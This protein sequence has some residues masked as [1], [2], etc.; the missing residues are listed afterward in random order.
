MATTLRNTIE[1]AAAPECKICF[2]ETTK[3]NPAVACP[4]CA[5]VA[6][7]T[8]VQT[9]LLGAG[10]EPR[11][12]FPECKLPWTQ[13][14]VDAST[15]ATW[16][17]RDLKKAREKFLCD[18][19]VARLP[20][21]QADAAR[22]AYA[23]KV[24][25]KAQALK[26]TAEE[27]IAN[28]SLMKKYEVATAERNTANKRCHELSAELYNERA[29]PIPN[30]LKIARLSAEH[31]EALATAKTK[32]A[33]FQKAQTHV[34]NSTVLKKLKSA[35]ALKV[36]AA[37]FRNPDDPDD[38]GMTY[39]IAKKTV[40]SYGLPQEAGAAPEERRAFIR[41]CPVTDCK[42]FLSSAWKCGLCSTYVCPDC[43][44]VKAARD[45]S[46]HKCDKE[47]VE[48]VRA[49]AKEARPCPK[50][51][52]AIS[53]IDGCDMMWCTLCQTAFSWRTGKPSSEEERIHNPHYYDWMRRNG[54]MI[55]RADDPCAGIGRVPSWRTIQQSRP[56]FTN[57]M[58]Q[59]VL[60]TLPISPEEKLPAFATPSEKERM[61]YEWNQTIAWALLMLIHRR[62]TEIDGGLN[63]RSHL[64]RPYRTEADLFR[65]LRVQYLVGELTKEEFAVK[66]QQKHKADRKK[67]VAHTLLVMLVTA[68][69][70][71]FRQMIPAAGVAAVP[72]DTI[73]DVVRALER[74]RIYYNECVATESKKFGNAF[75][76]VSWFHPFTTIYRVNTTTL[77]TPEHTIEKRW[78]D[79]MLMPNESGGPTPATLEPFKDLIAE[80]TRAINATEDPA[81][82]KKHEAALADLSKKVW[83]GL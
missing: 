43:H 70:D 58:V 63:G 71:I 55:P 59:D 66:L 1:G 22:Y 38:K 81:E 54:K 26:K 41:A 78:L 69:G 9:Y 49:I 77:T 82:K 51:A 68:A 40:E 4:Y 57:E 30:T 67:K 53:K 15:R 13:D 35:A 27:A 16:R 5:A 73:Y 12:P 83:R 39:S 64:I 14:F 79:H 46:A 6:C 62:I 36:S 8:C 28:D 24:V 34:K 44:D 56:A 42:G 21:T 76:E 18:L 45:D 65:T 80:H 20:D 47:K 60:Y 61:I 10:M 11:C 50:C 3:R 37:T 31:T 2:E 25:E 7:Q 48:S 32:E 75:Y 72:E 19:E 17:S 33:A 74:L 29:A 23:K 52:A